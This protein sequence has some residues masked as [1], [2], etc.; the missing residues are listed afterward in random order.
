MNTQLT[1][2][3]HH[4]RKRAKLTLAEVAAAL[5]LAKGSVHQ[6]ESGR[7]SPSSANLRR[8]APLLGV[9]LEWL[10][11][12]ESRLEDLDAPQVPITASVSGRGRTAVQPAGLVGMLEVTAPD[13]MELL[14]SYRRCAPD[15]RP[16]A[17]AAV[18]ALATQSTAAARKPKG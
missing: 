2:R 4:A 6:W 16:A 14:R 5:G 9:S 8:L 1:A 17:L 18:K 13:E 10:G 7:A 11:S 12:D 15:L 3:I